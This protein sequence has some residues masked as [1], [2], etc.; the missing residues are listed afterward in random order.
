M[1][2]RRLV[3]RFLVSAWLLGVPAP[4]TASDIASRT[5]LATG[6][7]VPGFGT[8]A[9]ISFGTSKA[10]CLADDGRVAV[11]ARSTTS[12]RRG[13]ICIDAAG[14]HLVV[15]SSRTAPDDHVFTNFSD[16]RFTQDGKLT[17]RGDRLVPDPQGSS[18]V[19][20]ASVYRAGSDGIEWLFGDGSEVR[21]GTRIE[22]RGFSIR[23]VTNSKGTVLAHEHA[24]GNGLF[25]SRD[26]RV[27]VVRYFP[28]D[29]YGLTD[30]DEVVTIERAHGWAPP[31]TSRSHGGNV[32]VVY[33]HGEA[34]VAMRTQEFPRADF[35][36][37]TNLRVRGD[38]A[39]FSEPRR[40]YGGSVTWAYRI[41]DDQPMQ[42]PPSVDIDT[43]IDF[44]ASG[45]ML[46]LV[47]NG[48]VVL[49]LDGM[50]LLPAIPNSSPF[51]VND[52]GHVA[53][54]GSD[55]S[56]E[57]RP[58]VELFG[59]DIDPAFACP[60]VPATP[61]STPTPTATTS[62]SPIADEGSHRLYFSDSQTDTLSVLDPD[63]MRTLRRTGVSHFPSALAVSA[64]GHRV[65]VL[66]RDKVDVVDA[67]T[68]E[69]LRT[70]RLGETG[71]NIV[72]APDSDRAYVSFFSSATQLGRTAVIDGSS[73]L[74]TSIL[75]PRGRVFA[76]GEDAQP[77]L[78]LAIEG[79]PCTSQ[80]FLLDIDPLS[81]DINRSMHLGMNLAAG[82]ISPDGRFAYLADRCGGALQTVDLLTF[83][84]SQTDALADGATDIVV[85]HSHHRVFVGSDSS[86]WLASSDGSWTSSRGRVTV[87]D[88]DSGSSEHIAIPGGVT[89]SITLGTWLYAAVG[90]QPL[91][92]LVAIDTAS[93]A[94]VSRVV[95]S[96]GSGDVVFAAAPAAGAP[97]PTPAGARVVVRP[98]DES[99]LF[100]QIAALAVSIDNGG[101]AV[102]SLDHDLITTFNA[103]VLSKG[104]RA[105]DCWLAA[106]INAM[107][108]FEF[109]Q[110]P[111]CGSYC[112]AV[113]VHID[114]DPPRGTLPTG[115]L[116]YCNIDPN[117]ARSTNPILIQHAAAADPNGLPLPAFGADSSLRIFRADEATAQPTPSPTTTPVRT[118]SATP[119]ATIT[120]PPASATPTIQLP[121]V[122]PPVIATTT[123]G[124]GGGNGCSTTGG[125]GSSPVLAIAIGGVLVLH[126]RRRGSGR[127]TRSLVRISP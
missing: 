59:P 25:L 62:P 113:H 4:S 97:S 61:R 44:T 29:L 33:D 122:T 93:H 92:E 13:L 77:M 55:D 28:S 22:D 68:L 109:P 118:A 76:I 43:I 57:H 69:V 50:P 53:A 67:T 125:S 14:P 123:S 114:S 36:G 5:V 86:T 45:R 85:D 17:F 47:A 81:G 31:S 84:A 52:R 63:T 95:P 54:F 91:G 79:G 83:E 56:I 72:A 78:A 46:Q 49:G 108:T 121:T 117:R 94:I 107:A 39:L 27:D 6:D 111:Y 80:S 15:D 82:A 112:N 11:V 124:G 75:A 64:D 74:V 16:C 127:A 99:A 58:T 90:S 87:I 73:E 20:Q 35:E 71:S 34:R 106:G 96:G 12:G 116:Y 2:L 115:V 126:R 38:L 98:A 110:V 120:V 51:A 89:P 100:G 10:G 32:L 3:A 21:N 26:G 37:F 104:T 19:M 105:P 70:L 102:G 18:G 8:I 1:S 48:A 65:F 40:L 60:Q 30:N 42:L 24:D 7:S 23:F 66:A 88:L 119:S 103:P 41:G 101:L 9:E